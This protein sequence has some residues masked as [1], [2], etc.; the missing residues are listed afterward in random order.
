MAKIEKDYEICY[1]H[2]LLNHTG[3]CSRLHGHNARIK[4]TIEGPTIKDSGRSDDGMVMDFE[5]I[6]HGVGTWLNANLDHRTIL[7][8][9]DPIINALVECG[10]SM[11]LVTIDMPPTAELLATFIHSHVVEWLSIYKT[12]FS[13]SV[14]FWETPKACAIVEDSSDY[15]TVPVRLLENELGKKEYVPSE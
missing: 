11:S 2:R 13:A 15:F 5:N 12:E 6:D 14:T 3:K 8:V 9:G 10:D 1:G 4:I 7:E